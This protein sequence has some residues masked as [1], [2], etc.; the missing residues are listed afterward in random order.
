MARAYALAAD[1]PTEL[2]EEEVVEAS[3]FANLEADVSELAN[4]TPSGDDEWVSF[5]RAQL[6]RL[7]PDFHD[8]E[9]H[10]A[11][12]AEGEVEG[13][14]EEGGEPAEPSFRSELLAMR[15]EIGVLRGIVAELS[16]N[17]ESQE[18]QEEAGFVPDAALEPLELDP[19]AVGLSLAIVR[20]LDASR[21]G[22]RPD[23][24][25]F[26]YDNLC[27]L[28]AATV[29]ATL[30]PVTSSAPDSPPA[31]APASPVFPSPHAAHLQLDAHEEME[32]ARDVS[33]TPE[34]G[35]PPKARVQRCEAEEM[36]DEELQEVAE[37][38]GEAQLL[39][40]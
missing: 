33:I 32:K 34:V 17:Q 31:P 22:V 3:S 4:L 39:V 16:E 25:V 28:L 21:S 27:A 15:T 8:A 20:A 11:G 35:T 12:D 37:M 36:C 18:S 29:S 23:S 9:G 1:S 7:F 13:Q 26:V 24:E 19:S 5:V 30:V 40:S 10:P 38:A 6:V 14:E 2:E